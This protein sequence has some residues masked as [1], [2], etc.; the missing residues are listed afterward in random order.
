MEPGFVEGDVGGNANWANA[1][2][3]DRRP[4]QLVDVRRLNGKRGKPL[5]STLQRGRYN[6]RTEPALV[7]EGN[8]PMGNAKPNLFSWHRFSL[9]T[10][11]TVCFILCIGLAW[12]SSAK[13]QR[14]A[15]QHLMSRGAAVY[16][17]E[18]N[19]LQSLA[20]WLPIDC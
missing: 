8:R 19:S 18:G 11:L 13:R 7:L 10:A 16:Y 2:D 17:D 12:Y 1:V 15:T 20:G 5:L 9:R 6:Q 4:A 3:T 14:D